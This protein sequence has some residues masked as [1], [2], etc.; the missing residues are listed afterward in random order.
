MRPPHP[1]KPHK[2]S[3]IRTTLSK[4]EDSAR[5]QLV[6]L[7][8]S[9]PATA[10]RP[11]HE[12]LRILITVDT[13]ISLGGALEDPTK[14]PVGVGRR[15]WGDTSK[16]R[17]GIELLMDLLER[18]SMRGVFF[19]EPMARH[20]VP[21]AELKEAAQHIAERGHDVELHIHPEFKLD[22]DKVR[23]GEQTAP[24]PWLHSFDQSE[25]SAYF[26]EAMTELENWTGQ[27]PTTF[28]AG[29]YATDA[30][31]LD[32]CADKR[33]AMDSSYNLWAIQAGLCKLAPDPALNDVA[34]LANGI[35][36]IPV[37]NLKTRGPMSGLRPFELSSLNVSEMITAVEQLYEAGA[38]T[39]CTM[40]HSF[41]LIRTTNVQYQN[42]KPD[43]F[44]IRRFHA[45]LRYLDA[46]RDRFTVCTYRDLPLDQWRNELGTPPT[47][48]FFPTPPR[49]SS[50][51]RMTLQAIKDLGAL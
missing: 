47:D 48:P 8:R 11:N 10:P 46:H 18:Y 16:G 43:H 9:R 31:G 33:L 4:F 20:L 36:E 29:S 50:I 51:S 42:A 44:N 27:R 13:E 2:P 40:T 30:V 32:V 24:H 45:L 49:W 35:F 39:C 38:R 1:A 5:S 23:R 17:Y 21:E 3:A 14:S 34:L 19:F 7:T 37:T 26:A 41:R 22:I 6:S 12:P 15:I 25:Q 28:R